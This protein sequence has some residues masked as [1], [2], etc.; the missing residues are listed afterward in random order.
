MRRHAASRDAASLL[1]GILRT[2]LSVA[3]P[4]YTLLAAWACLSGSIASACSCCLNEC[5]SNGSIVWL[6]CAHSH[7]C[8][9]CPMRPC[10][11]LVWR[12]LLGDGAKYLEALAAAKTQGAETCTRI[13]WAAWAWARRVW[14]A[15][16][17]RHG[18]SVGLGLAETR[19]PPQ[20]PNLEK[21]ATIENKLKNPS[22]REDS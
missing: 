8:A 10:V 22:C 9:Y 16:C 1:L 6:N 12:H 11:L 4:C 21:E 7:P 15:K 13:S 14:P 18:Y 3:A 20:S 2:C 19:L 5:Y 17:V